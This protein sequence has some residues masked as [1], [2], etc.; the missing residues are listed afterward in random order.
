MSVSDPSGFD[1]TANDFYIPLTIGPG[2]GH[3]LF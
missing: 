3:I 1:H 2:T